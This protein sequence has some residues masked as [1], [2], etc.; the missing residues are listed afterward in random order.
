MH[1]A[2]LFLIKC[3]FFFLGFGFGPARQ[4]D[5]GADGVVHRSTYRK[6]SGGRD[7]HNQHGRCHSHHPHDIVIVTAHPSVAVSQRTVDG[8]VGGY[9]G[10]HGANRV[11]AGRRHRPQQRAAVS[12]HVHDV[13]RRIFAAVHSG[14]SR[15]GR[16]GRQSAAT[17]D[18]VAGPQ[19]RRIQNRRQPG[20][21]PS[22]GSSEEPSAHELR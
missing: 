7:H 19:R 15:Y 16:G 14:G 10:G 11:G 5:Y 18:P 9:S 17:D 2:Y 20:G 13:H 8:I 22:V 3:F 12:G 21:G 6:Y 1:T 4:F